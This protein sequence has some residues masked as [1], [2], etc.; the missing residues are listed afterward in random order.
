M[1]KKTRARGSKGTRRDEREDEKIYDGGP[2]KPSFKR[3]AATLEAKIPN[4]QCYINAI[5]SSIITFGIGPAG[6]GKTYIPTA[7]AALD[8]LSGN[9]E[10]IV[11]VRPAVEAGEKLGYLPGDVNEKIDPYMRPIFDVLGRFLDK[12]RLSQ[13]I[14]LGL[15]EIAPLAYMRG[16]SIPDA[17]II[18]D[19]AQNTTPTQMKMFLTRIGE[20]SKIVITG[21]PTQCDIVPRQKSGLIDAI[22]R[23]S[24]VKG[25]S[26]IELGVEDIVRHDIVQAIVE[27][28]E[29]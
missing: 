6:C 2:F 10:K 29:I 17:Y 7:M 14:Q 16:R 3:K 1:R 13:F 28:Y 20:N 22:E 21:D 18:L 5:E 9:I 25:I 8:L 12:E 26:T 15:V 19:E 23:L 27:A 4:Q 24:D 11:L